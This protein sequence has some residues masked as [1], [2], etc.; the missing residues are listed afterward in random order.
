MEPASKI[1][2]FTLQLS[3]R[4][5]KILFNVRSFT[6]AATMSYFWLN[7]RYFNHPVVIAQ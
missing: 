5:A 3:E 4:F 1:R 6:G 7:K 2:L